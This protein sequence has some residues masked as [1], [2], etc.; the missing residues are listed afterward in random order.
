MLLAVGAPPHRVNQPAVSVDVGGSVDQ[1]V[2]AVATRSAMSA[3]S[4]SMPA[5]RPPQA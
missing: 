5:S 2:A 1:D 3:A 4:S